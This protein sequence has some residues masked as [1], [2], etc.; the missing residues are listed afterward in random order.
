MSYS[1][2]MC[3]DKDENEAENESFRSFWIMPVRNEPSP[4]YYIAYNYWFVHHR[5]VSEHTGMKTLV[6]VFV[7]VFVLVDEH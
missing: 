6:F 5:Y 7:F 2:F 3:Q 1:L 4:Y